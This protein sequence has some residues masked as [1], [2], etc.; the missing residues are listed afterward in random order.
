MLPRHHVGSSRSALIVDPTPF[1]LDRPPD[2]EFNSLRITKFSQRLRCSEGEL[3]RRFAIAVGVAT[4]VAAG[5]V[6]A[7]LTKC[8]AGIEKNGSKL[9]A[10]IL[11]AFTKCADGF[12]KANGVPATVATSATSCQGGLNKALDF[13]NDAIIIS[14]MEKTKSA[15]DKLTTFVPPASPVCTSDDLSRLGHLRT[16]LFGD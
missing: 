8:Q 2:A 14:A 1:F 10:T 15:L 5:P 3:M 11:K 12:R 9:E 7:D 16:D 4:L 13:G 6:S